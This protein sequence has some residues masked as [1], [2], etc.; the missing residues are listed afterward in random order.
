MTTRTRKAKASLLNDRIDILNKDAAET[1]AAK[2]VFRTVSATLALVR[3][4]VPI[5]GRFEGP[6]R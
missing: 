2:Q 4:S 6:R 3:V 5:L 1:S